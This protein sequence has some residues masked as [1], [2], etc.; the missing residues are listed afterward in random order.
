[1]LLRYADVLLMKAEA[2]LSGGQDPD[3]AKPES[4]VNQIRTRAQVPVLA[5]VTLNTLFE[6]RS[7]EMAWE[8]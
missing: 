2:I 3:G 5:T 1:M 8:G 4:L 7:R 6:E